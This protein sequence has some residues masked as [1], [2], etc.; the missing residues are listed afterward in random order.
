MSHSLEMNALL[1]DTAHAPLR[2]VAIDRPVPAAGQVLVRIKASGI[3][4]LD[5][6]VRAGQ[7]GHARQPLPAVLGMDLAG[8]IEALG[9]GVD[10]WTVGDEVYGMATGI[11]G[12]QGSLAEFAAVDA[13]LLARKPG[14]L[15]MR[16][17]AALPLVLITAW[18]G[19]VD[20]A[21]VSAGQ[22][23]LIHGGAG[24]VG[25]VA[26]QIAKAFGARVFA[27]GSARHQTVIEGFGATFIDYRHHTVQDYVQQH[28]V[29]EGF[30]IVYDTVGGETLDESFQAARTYHGHVLS[31]LGW[32]QHSLA[33]LS[34]RGATYSGVFTL[35]PLLTGQGRDHHGH[36]LAEAAR[37]IEA[38][39]LKP[40]LDPRRF[41]L[42]TAEEAYTLLGNGA[43]Q[44]RLVVEI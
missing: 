43:A 34:F 11:G 4:P 36:I 22:A 41:T 12:A 13:R 7:A 30:D 5:G 37:L 25:H 31:C 1:V 40:L 35:L 23:V 3:N 39:Q 18:E 17:A 6:K 26:V 9:E 15:S 32:G 19:L 29:G 44:G 28:T 42:Q 38:G 8:V 10:G 2:L 20:R 24:G 27:T 21:R 16:E 33:P 14:N